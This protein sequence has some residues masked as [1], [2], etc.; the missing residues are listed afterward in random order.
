MPHIGLPVCNKVALAELILIMTTLSDP[1]FDPVL[2]NKS[3][4]SLTFPKFITTDT[5]TH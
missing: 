1:R 4:F 5:Q 3:N 2:K